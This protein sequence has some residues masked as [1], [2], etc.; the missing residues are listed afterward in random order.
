MHAP[1]R[2][3]YP[4][5]L[6]YSLQLCVLHDSPS[7]EEHILDAH[8][9]NSLLSL[10]GRPI[11][12]ASPVLIGASAPCLGRSLLR[13]VVPSKKWL[14]ELQVF[15]WSTKSFALLEN[16]GTKRFGTTYEK[17]ESSFTK[18]TRDLLIEDTNFSL[19]R[20][21]IFALAF[22]I[23]STAVIDASLS[24]RLTCCLCCP[25]SW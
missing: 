22:P 25:V 17:S 16:S 12:L 24:P 11:S 23:S 4:W 6:L 10:A 18:G 15:T 7:L 20:H 19:W 3:Q 2:A 9:D 1:S 21:D 8:I 13:G 5:L 14:V